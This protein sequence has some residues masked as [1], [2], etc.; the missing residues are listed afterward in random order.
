MSRPH[1]LKP[2]VMIKPQ[3]RAFQHGAC[4][5]HIAQT[6]PMVVYGE[7]KLA[8]EQAQLP[9]DWRALKLRAV[10]LDAL[11]ADTGLAAGSTEA[12]AQQ[13]GP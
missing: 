5:N 4:M 10:E 13:V 8:S 11:L 7:L 6:W 12:D 2:A 3:R 9:V 1:P